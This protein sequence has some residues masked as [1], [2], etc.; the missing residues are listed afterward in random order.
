MKATLIMVA[1][2]AIGNVPVALSL[3]FKPQDLLKLAK[4]QGLV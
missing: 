4:T 3:C 2:A 1:T